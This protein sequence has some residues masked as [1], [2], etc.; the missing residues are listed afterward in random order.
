LSLL[1][2]L[3]EMTDQQKKLWL[4]VA[5]KTGSNLEARMVYDELLK[6]L[7]M[8]EDTVILSLVETENGI[9]VHLNEKAYDNFAVIGLIERIKLDLLS[10]PDLPIHDLRKKTET[11]KPSQKYDA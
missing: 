6:K 3:Y 11:E 10:R 1:S 2:L 8:S 9:E 7:N 5:E 4:H